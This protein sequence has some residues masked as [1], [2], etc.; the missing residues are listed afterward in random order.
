[1]KICI[2][3]SGHSPLDDRIF[4]KEALSLRKVYDDITIIGPFEEKYKEVNGI[5]ILGIPKEKT[6]LGRIKHLNKLIN[7]AINL[8]ANIYH[9]HDYEIILYASQIKRALPNSK[10]IY[11]VHEH[12]PDM[13]DAS[14]K[15]PKIL[16]PIIRLFVESSENILSRN[17]DY[18]LTA[19]DAV[20]ER[21]DKFNRNVDIIYNFSDFIPKESPGFNKEYDIIY[22][23]GISRIR[24]V[25]QL[26]KAVKIIKKEKNDIRMIFVGTFADSECE[27]EVKEYIKEKDLNSNIFFKGQVPHMEVEGYI[28]KSRIG[29]VTL[30]PIPKF[31]KNIPIK[32]FEYMSCGIPIVGSRLPPI[33]KFVSEAECGILVNPLK[34]EEI[35]KAILELLNDS[36][37]AEY[38]GKNGMKAVQ[39]K[40]NW[41]LMEK[42]M[43]AIY[44][45]LGG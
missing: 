4:Y 43:R 18:I 22:Q 2:L 32:Q 41:K 12:Y 8:K 28:R 27:K 13:V 14:Y 9:F 31:F 25:I 36:N 29:V 34:P 37:R 38:L 39:E 24:G 5:K 19:D 6:L 42:K 40:Y 21:F 10:I 30:L 3:T 20:K 7:E 44:K 16:K 23:G 26:V 35:A 17:Y 15:I 33:Q 11:D 45:H 1:M